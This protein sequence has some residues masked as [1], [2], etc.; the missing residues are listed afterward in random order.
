MWSLQ[1]EALPH[2]HREHSHMP[3]TSNPRA[4]SYTATN[5]MA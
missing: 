2:A 1:H 5:K 3:I 4:V